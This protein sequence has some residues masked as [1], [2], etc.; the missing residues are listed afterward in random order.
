[1][2]GK[3][4]RKR[5]AEPVR[6]STENVTVVPAEMYDRELRDSAQ[7]VR[8][9]S[10]SD[11]ARRAE[12]TVRRAPVPPSQS[13]SPSPRTRSTFNDGSS[14]LYTSSSYGSSSSDCGSSGSSSSSSSTDSGSSGSCDSGGF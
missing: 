10:L 9:Q 8:N 2:F 7:P 11:A 6:R 1:M 3:W 13:S 12:A 4:F 14:Y 5:K